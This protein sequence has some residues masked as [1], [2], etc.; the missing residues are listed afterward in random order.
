MVILFLFFFIC[1]KFN[2]NLLRWTET[3][4]A[5][6]ITEMA[7]LIK[8][9]SIQHMSL[10]ELKLSAAVLILISTLIGGYWPIR[11]RLQ[12]RQLQTFYIGDAL[13]SGIF[14][15]AALFHMLP[16][17]ANQFHEMY[18]NTHFPYAN[19]LCALAFVSLV[20]LQRFAANLVRK[21][22]HQHQ[23]KTALPYILTIV[24]CVHSLVSAM[25]LGINAD[26]SD[27][28]IIFVA[29]TAHKITEAFALSTNLHR[30]MVTTRQVVMLFLIFCLMTPL[31]ITVGYSMSD[32]FVSDTSALFGIAFNAIAAGTFLY[33]ATVHS[34]S[35]TELDEHAG[36]HHHHHSL[37][38]FSALLAGLAIM[39]AVSAVH[40]H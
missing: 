14:L 28:F 21:P 30:S 39:A 16:H 3:D 19:I 34:A 20:F 4:F 11:A 33:M 24:L 13:A 40:V 38:E 8:S 37:G 29:I 1:V 23:Q 25:A 15:G 35:H 5:Y 9:L 26:F 27:T 31:G 22:N 36:H 18:P 12:K 6:D 2:C 7:Y 32:A 17:A 10:F